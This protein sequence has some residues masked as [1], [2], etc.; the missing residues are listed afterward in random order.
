MT[1]NQMQAFLARA[2]DAIQ[3]HE[4]EPVTADHAMGLV[5][6]AYAMIQHELEKDEPSQEAQR[7]KLGRFKRQQ[8]G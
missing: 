4:T 7:S 3:L 2:G 1:K 6:E 8:A 5:V